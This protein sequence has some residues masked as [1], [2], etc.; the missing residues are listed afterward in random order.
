VAR[1]QALRERVGQARHGSEQAWR[2]RAGWEMEDL[3]ACA[4]L[5]LTRTLWLGWR[6]CRTNTFAKAG[7]ARRGFGDPPGRPLSLSL[8]LA[9]PKEPPRLRQQRPHL[10]L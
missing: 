8:S 3:T 5:P 9:A 2:P 7:V 10:A 6:V 4:A 1:R